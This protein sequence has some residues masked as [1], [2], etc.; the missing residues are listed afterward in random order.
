M[1]LPVPLEEFFRV[2]EYEK[3]FSTFDK[4]GIPLTNH[5]G[6]DV[7]KSTRKKLLKKRQKHDG[8]QRS[9]YNLTIYR[10]LHFTTLNPQSEAFFEG[11]MS[12]KA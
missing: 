10:Y 9:L 12:L 3:A 7:S 1:N 2:G 8:L 4:V 11:F 5:N 6:T